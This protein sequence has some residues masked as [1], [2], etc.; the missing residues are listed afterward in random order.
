MRTYRI[1]FNGESVT[2]DNENEAE[3]QESVNCHWL[4]CVDHIEARGGYARMFS[5]YSGKET[6]FSKFVK[7]SFVMDGICYHEEK[8]IAE[9]GGKQSRAVVIG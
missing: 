8:L 4:N 7:D 6:G 2:H 1:E 3:N 5:S 9:I